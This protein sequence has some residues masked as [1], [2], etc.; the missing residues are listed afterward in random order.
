MAHWEVRDGY[1][2]LETLN[3]GPLAQMAGHSAVCPWRRLH[4]RA[5]TITTYRTTSTQLG[6]VRSISLCNRVHSIN[7]R[8][9]TMSDEQKIKHY[10]GRIQNPIS[11]RVFTQLAAA[12]GIG[13][14]LASAFG[15]AA[16]AQKNAKAAT[17]VATPSNDYWAAFIKG[18]NAT[19]TALEIEATELYHNNDAARELSQVRGLP[20]QG[21]NM[22]INTVVSAGEV[23]MIARIC[24]E[25]QVYYSALWETPA[26]FSPVD[27]GPYFVSYMTA[28]SV[29]AGYQVGKALFESIGGEGE[30]VH[31]KGLATPTD[32]ARTAGMMKAAKEF[33]GITIVG[34]QRGDWVREKARKVML[35]MVT[36]YPNMKAVFAQNDSMALGALSVLKERGLTDVKV[37]GIDGLSEG[38]QEVAKGD[39]FVA[40]NTSMGPYQAGFAAVLLFDSLMGWKASL[41]ERLL[42]TGSLTAT[43]ANAAE[44]D[45]KIYKSAE[46][47]FDWAKMS[48]TLNP[49][50]WDPQNQIVPIDPFS[51]W[52]GADGENRLNAAYREGGWQAEFERVTQLYADHYKAGP[53]K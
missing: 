13:V 42:Y 19:A 3:P 23:P 18:F 28:N 15:G 44:I 38:L 8:R 11:R 27:V 16:F 2:S 14:P 41:P 26:W 20:T 31:I 45:E 52:A 50:S 7:L 53:F 10:A 21:V 36:A 34:G 47:P 48:R 9:I 17:C 6:P 29:E 33:P 5:W 37:A 40:T 43:T 1:F 4:V 25:N 39:Q 32:D 46:F 51:H 24:Q 49:D 22:L 12:A 35:S 30:V